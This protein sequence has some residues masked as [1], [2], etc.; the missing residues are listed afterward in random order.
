MRK[1]NPLRVI[2]NMEWNDDQE[3]EGLFVSVFVFNTKSKASL[4]PQ[5]CSVG[6]PVQVPEDPSYSGSFIQFSLLISSGH[7]LLGVRAGSCCLFLLVWSQLMN[8]GNSTSTAWLEEKKSLMDSGCEEKSAPGLFF[9]G[10]GEER[11]QSGCYLAVSGGRVR[12]DRGF[13][14]GVKE[15]LCYIRSGSKVTL[16]RPHPSPA[17]RS[18]CFGASVLSS[19]QQ[20]TPVYQISFCLNSCPSYEEIS[21]RVNEAQL[22]PEHFVDLASSGISVF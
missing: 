5:T 14:A 4:Q 1:G 12:L 13:P 6:I 21:P 10:K 16:W 17:F 11:R 7:T 9:T 2:W 19:S 20:N 3:W 22:L 15:A 8:E 18:L